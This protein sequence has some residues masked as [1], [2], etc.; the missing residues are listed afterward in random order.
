MVVVVV[1]VVDHPEDPA[2]AND[3][4]EGQASCKQSSGGTDL[5]QTINQ[6]GWPLANDHPEGPASRK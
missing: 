1:V 2:L 5:L 3:D 4:L 6:R